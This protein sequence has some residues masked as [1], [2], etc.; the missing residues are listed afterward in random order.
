MNDDSVKLDTPTHNAGNSPESS[1]PENKEV[2]D[3]NASE[4]STCVA[5]R[6]DK[7]PKNEGDKVSL[8]LVR[9]GRLLDEQTR[10]L[11]S[12]HIPLFLGLMGIA[13]LFF[14]DF[15]K[16]KEVFPHTASPFAALVVVCLIYEIISLVR[17]SFNYPF[18]V[19]SIR[20]LCDNEFKPPSEEFLKKRMLKSQKAISFASGVV[21]SIFTGLVSFTVLLLI[22][23]S[24]LA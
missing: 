20:L 3:V 17:L 7:L 4:T 22:G 11:Y 19:Y 10:T 14:L 18:D 9:D 21:F 5:S 2:A 1:V 16:I 15:S 12:A 24:I 6:Q 23:E 13:V 8:E